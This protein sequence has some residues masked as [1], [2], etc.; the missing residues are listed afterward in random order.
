MNLF[1]RHRPLSTYLGSLVA[2]FVLVFT[3][4]LTPLAEAADHKYLVYVG[5]Y[6]ESGS[7]GIYAYRFD[8]GTGE[9]NSLGLTAE[10][11]DPAFL[12]ADVSGTFLYAANEINQ[13]NGEKSGAVS[14]FAIDQN[15]G[16]LTLL[17]RISSLGAMP[18][19]VSLDKTGRYL[20]VA[21]YGGGSVAAFPVQNDGR[22][23]KASSFVQHAGS[24]VNHDR[25]TAPHPHEVVPTSDD[26]FVL[27]PDLGLDEVLI[28]RFDAAKGSLI[29]NDPP[30][31][32]ADP[33][34]GP[35]HLALHPNGRF[36]YVVNELQSTVSVFSYD[37]LAG[38]LHSLQTLTTLPKDF[39]GQ[40]STAE[41]LTDAKGGFLYLSNRGNDSIAVF[42]IDS[43][44]GTLSPVQNI[45][46]GG[47]TP[48]NFA[49]DPTGLWLFVAN[50]DSNN[51]A[52]FRID[53]HT[54][55]LTRTQTV[56][57]IAAPAC[58]IFVPYAR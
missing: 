40:N 14:A 31:A 13:F 50:Q 15:A 39:N 24:S 9:V 42:A 56:L 22:L 49:I 5:T 45:P 16:K 7:K 32:K 33:G 23:G 36:A 30:F 18:A 27:V 12:A 53:S 11:E 1:A 25:Q 58:V 4:P 48:R 44:N 43:K 6:T 28:Y 10:T 41:I 38:S 34:S 46:S 47:R 2:L 19:H 52:L 17:N 35:R 29:P 55:L 20:L 3:L 51:I 54:G 37:T 57:Q 21:N 26:R 8:A